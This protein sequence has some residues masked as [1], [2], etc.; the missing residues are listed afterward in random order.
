MSITCLGSAPQLNHRIIKIEDGLPVTCVLTALSTCMYVRICLVA[1]GCIIRVVI[2]LMENWS[3]GI[4]YS[5]MCKITVPVVLLYKSIV[6]G[7][8]TE[9]KYKFMNTIWSVV[10]CTR[11][12]D[13]ISIHV[14]YDS[15]SY[16][17]PYLS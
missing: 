1:T 4:V 8:C 16:T 9:M 5:I 13:F 14:N 2:S 17:Q 12:L 6:T 10:N 11:L 7:Y 15:D 3:E